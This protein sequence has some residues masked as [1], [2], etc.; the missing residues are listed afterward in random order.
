MLNEV[1]VIIRTF[2]Q[3]WKLRCIE[4]DLPEVTQLVKDEIRC[5]LAN[6]GP[7][8]SH[9]RYTQISQPGKPPRQPCLE[10]TEPVFT[11]SI[12]GHHLREPC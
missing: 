11:H 5:S 2:V 9:T 4:V 6:P 12:L 7:A 3:M 10:T 1:S 8:V